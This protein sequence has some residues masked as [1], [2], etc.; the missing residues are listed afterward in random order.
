MFDFKKDAGSIEGWLR[1]AEGM[2]LYERAQGAQDGA[3]VEI[4]SW[5][6]RSTVC[7]GSGSRDGLRQTVY[8]IDPHSGA[9]EQKKAFGAFLDT[10]EEFEENIRRAG[11]QEFVRPIRD[12]SENAA[13]NFN[14][15][16][17]FIFI[18]GAHEYKFVNLDFQLWFPKV[19]NGGITAFHDSWHRVGPHL[20]TALLLLFSSEIK[21]PRLIGTITC[22]EKVERNSLGDRVRNIVFLL[23]RPLRGIGTFLLSRALR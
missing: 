11:L 18:D 20:T 22:F 2:F 15:P 21:N 19:V 17:S 12:T 4:G 14:E 23:V 6:G 10:F 16:V 8:A 5:K 9:S 3:I 13:R 7:L 1:E